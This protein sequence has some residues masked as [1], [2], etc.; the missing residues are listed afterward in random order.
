LSDVEVLDNT[1]E[2]IGLSELQIKA[3]ECLTVQQMSDEETAEYLGVELSTISKWLI[4]VPEFQTALKNGW[5]SK[6]V[7]K[8]GEALKTIDF[9]QKNRRKFPKLAAELGMEMVKLTL[10]SQQANVTVNVQSDDASKL[11]EELASKAAA[12]YGGE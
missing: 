6:L 7:L 3:I 11:I 4:E 12:R 1:E 2:V 5:V 10:L 9:I 8:S